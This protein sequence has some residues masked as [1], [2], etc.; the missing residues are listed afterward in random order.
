M[1][2]KAFLTDSNMMDDFLGTSIQF[3]EKQLLKMECEYDLKRKNEI[4]DLIKSG[5]L[6][7]DYDGSSGEYSSSSD[8]EEE[9]IPEPKTTNNNKDESYQKKIDDYYSLSNDE[10]NLVFIA[11]IFEFEVTPTNSKFQILFI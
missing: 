3:S 9:K 7:S 6:D 10:S 2:P 4:D 5:F 1:G 8:E 11:F